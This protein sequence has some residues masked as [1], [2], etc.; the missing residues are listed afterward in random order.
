MALFADRPAADE[1]TRRGREILG[2]VTD[3]LRERGMALLEADTDGVYF[4]APLGWTEEQERGVVAAAAALLPE[5]IRLE[6]EGR[7]QAMF[8]HEVKNYALLTYGGDIIVRGGALRS[9]RSEPFGERFL[10]EA[11]RCILVG[12]VAGVHQAFL[13]VVDALRHRRL[14]AMDVAIQARLSKTPE[15]YASL[16]QARARGCVRGAAYGRPHEPGRSASASGSIKAADGT[17]IWLPDTRD[18][19]SGATAGEETDRGGRAFSRR[20]GRKSRGSA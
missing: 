11:L 3:A 17:V 15:E 4:A 9:S 14:T 16:T 10:R 13:E 2:Q 18:D 8:V 6:Y 5:G 20:T 7:Y 12:N 1:V 19:L